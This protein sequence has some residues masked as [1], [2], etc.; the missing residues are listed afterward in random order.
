MIIK[1]SLA[2]KKTL[3]ALDPKGKGARPWQTAREIGSVVFRKNLTN[4]ES[5]EIRAVRNA[6]RKL[7]R[8]D[9]VEMSPTDRGSYCITDAGRKLVAAGFP[10]FEGKFVRGEATIQSKQASAARAQQTRPK[11]KKVRVK[12]S[13]KKVAEPKAPKPGKKPS[14]KAVKKV[15]KKATKKVGRKAPKKRSSKRSKSATAPLVA[16]EAP[17]LLPIAISEETLPERKKPVFKRRQALLIAN[18]QA[19]EQ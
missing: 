9:L 6:F 11:V 13:A 17:V 8:E 12:K 14:K 4:L 15:A 19:E 3:T 18:G 7:V 1:L 2:E 10:D 16:A 5:G